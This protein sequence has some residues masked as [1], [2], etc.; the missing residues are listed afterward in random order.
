MSTVK[1][2]QE[3][4]VALSVALHRFALHELRWSTEGEVSVLVRFGEANQDLDIGS[5]QYSSGNEKG[6]ASW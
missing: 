3:N 1:M 5:F 6:L 4:Y 2:Q